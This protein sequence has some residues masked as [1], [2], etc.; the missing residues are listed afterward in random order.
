M[1][2][3][4]EV[5]I[6]TCSQRHCFRVRSECGTRV[7]EVGP[8]MVTECRG[9]WAAPVSPGIPRLLL[10]IEVSFRGDRS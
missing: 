2:V 7:G 5:S 3:G 1:C 9:A 10:Q 4:G 8:G 6:L